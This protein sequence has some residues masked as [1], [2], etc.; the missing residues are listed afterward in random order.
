MRLFFEFCNFIFIR[1]YKLIKYL[2][3]G[4]IFTISSSILFIF[5]SKYISRIGSIMIV[6]PIVYLLKFLIYKFW[7]FRK[8]SVDIN[9]F[10]LHMIPQ[11]F[12][13]IVIA[14]ITDNI[15]RVDYV[16]LIIILVN[17]FIGYFWGNFLYAYKK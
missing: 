2:I 1:N 12:I 5:L 9:N 10:I 16:A 14:K 4:G 8:D 3:T 17:S 13:S 6:T 11:Y 7:V 15:P